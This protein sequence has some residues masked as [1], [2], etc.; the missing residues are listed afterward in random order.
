MIDIHCHILPG[1]DDGATDLECALAMCR[2]AA[3]DGIRKIVAT[4]HINTTL[5]PAG[6]IT[7]RIAQLNDQLTAGGLPLEILAGADVSARIDPALLS[8][9]AINGTN[10]ILIEFPHTHLP[11]NAGEI[12]FQ[13]TINGFR[14]IITHPERNPSILQDPRLLF[15]LTDAGCL[16]QITAS[17]LTGEFGLGIEE[18]A[19]YLV[20]KKVVHFLATDAHSPDYRRPVLSEALEKAG[21]LIGREQAARLVTTNPTAVLA[22]EPINA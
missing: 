5:T 17:S 2:I 6:E 7:D 22:G 19:R 18:C 20:K 13:F 8:P 3:A 9:Y 15:A 14:P 16:V 21:K 4:P 12:V 1:I 10:Y 11:R